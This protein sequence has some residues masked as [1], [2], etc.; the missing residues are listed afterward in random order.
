MQPRDV[1]DVVGLLPN[2]TFLSLVPW[3]WVVSPRGALLDVLLRMFT[4]SLLVETGIGA[5]WALPLISGRREPTGPP[6]TTE[7]VLGLGVRVLVGV[8][9]LRHVVL[10]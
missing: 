3:T 6:E 9:Q 4:K 7:A 10:R 5:R 8:V 1:D 2:V